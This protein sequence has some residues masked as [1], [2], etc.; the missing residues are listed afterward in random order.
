MVKNA[1]DLLLQAKTGKGALGRLVNDKQ[2]GDNLA[3]F[4]A[5]LKAHGPIFYKD[6]STGKASKD[7]SADK[8]ARTERANK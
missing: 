1:N 5:N 4:I 2:V 7:E 8:P 3:T 6:D